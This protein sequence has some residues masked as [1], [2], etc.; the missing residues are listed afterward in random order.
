MRSNRG[1]AR[2]CHPRSS[3]QAITFILEAAAAADP[4]A[5][6]PKALAVATGGFVAAV[7]EGWPPMTCCSELNKLARRFCAVPTGVGVAV[8][9]EESVLGSSGE[10]FL[11]PWPWP[12]GGR[13]TAGRAG[14]TA[15]GMV[16]A[17]MGYPLERCITVERQQSAADGR[18]RRNLAAPD[19]GIVRKRV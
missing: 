13:F 1:A 9:L 12:C 19:G 11:W 16:N 8:L 7:V 4:A 17:D 3:D 6:E 5:A 15:A 18:R 10:V 14:V 2:S